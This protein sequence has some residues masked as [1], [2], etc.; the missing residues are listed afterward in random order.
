MVEPYLHAFAHLKPPRDRNQWN[1]VYRNAPLKALLLLAVGD[2]IAE[3]QIRENRIALL[4]VIAS[5]FGLYWAAVTGTQAHLA[6]LETAFA[7]LADDPFWH[8]RAEH[9][10]L[11]VVENVMARIFRPRGTRH[12]AAASLDE[13]LFRC[14]QQDAP[15]RR[16][17]QTLIETYVPQAR[18]GRLA[19]VRP[20]SV[21]QVGEM[22]GGDV[23]SRSEVDA[24][25]TA[26]ET[27]TA[28]LCGADGAV[29]SDGQASEDARGGRLAEPMKDEMPAEAE[30]GAVAVPLYVG[31]SAAS[32]SAIFI[33]PEAASQVVVAAP[34]AYPLELELHTPVGTR[35]VLVAQQSIEG[36]PLVADHL[37]KK[38]SGTGYDF[39]VEWPYVLDLSVR[40]GNTL[41]RHNIGKVGV[42]AGQAV[43]DLMRM[44]N[45]GIGSLGEVIEAL[46]N[47]LWT[48]LA[49][50]T[51]D[52]L[53]PLRPAEMN[54]ASPMARDG[55]TAPVIAA[56]AAPPE[57]THERHASALFADVVS[58][59]PHAQA[60]YPEVV[61]SASR[62]PDERTQTGFDRLRAALALMMD[63]AALLDAPRD[64]PE[65]AA[66]L[67]D[68]L[69][70]GV[71]I[72][73]L[74][75]HV[76]RLA[77]G[78]ADRARSDLDVLLAR[79]GV[80]DGEEK[81]LAEVG[82]RRNL[83]RERIRQ[84]E[85]AAQ[86][87]LEEP[88]VALDVVALGNL[89]HLAVM[90]LG[91][92]A[93][94]S[95][96]TEWIARL[97]PFGAV[98]PTCTTRLI[99][100]WSALRRMEGDRLALS[101]C[102]DTLIERAET[103]IRETL[104]AYPGG[105]AFDD[106]VWRAQK[107][108]GEALM[109]AQCAFVAAVVR[110]SDEVELVDGECRPAYR[111]SLQA[112]I[113]AAL[114]RLG[115]PAHFSEIAATYRRLNLDD[116]GRTDHTVHAFIGR[117]PD[118]FVLAGNGTFALADWGY[119]PA[120][121]DVAGAVREVL[122]QAE[123][124]LHRDE[125]VRLVGERYRWKANSIAAAL[126]TDKRIRAFGN[127][128][129]G[130]QRRDYGTFDPRAAYTKQFGVQK[131][132]KTPTVVDVYTNARGNTVTHLCLTPPMLPGRIP[133]SNKP[134]RECFA[135][136]G[137]L[138][139]L[140][141]APSS[142]ATAVTLH[143]GG[144]AVTGLGDWFAA[145]GVK[146]G[147][148]LLV[149]RLADAAPDEPRYL[150]VHAP[151][152]HE[153]EAM[154][155]V[156]LRADGW[157]GGA[158]ADGVQVLGT[159]NLDAVRQLVWHALEQPWTEISSAQ[160]VLGFAHVG[161]QGS[162]YRRLGVHCGALADGQVP[163][164]GDGLF[165]RPTRW[166]RAWAARGRDDGDT[167]NLQR[168]LALRLPPYRR[169]LRG[170]SQVEG[171]S[172]ALLSP[173]VLA[174]WERRLGLAPG[175]PQ[176]LAAV[177]ATAAFVHQREVRRSALALLLL[178]LAAQSHGLGVA[179]AALTPGGNTVEAIE[180][181]RAQGIALV[182]DGAGRA[183][184][185]ERVTLGVDDAQ[186]LEHR[187]RDMDT[188]LATAL[189]DAWHTVQPQFTA[190][191]ELCAAELFTALQAE[192]PALVREVVTTAPE[193]VSDVARYAEGTLVD[194]GF[195]Q[196]VGDFGWAREQV[197]TPFAFWRDADARAADPVRAPMGIC[198]C[199][200]LMQWPWD[201]PRHL[202]ANAHLA[203][204]AVLASDLGG[205]AER[206][207]H[208]DAGWELSGGPLV[209]G[210]DRAL[211]G[212]G[213]DLWDEHYRDDLAALDALAD[214]LMTLGER[215]GLLHSEGPSVVAIGSLASDLYY[216]AYYAEHDPI[217]RV[218]AALA[219]VAL[220]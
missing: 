217:G 193:A 111:G 203:L 169:H 113:I 109:P 176:A 127:A 218:R 11:G 177:E 166:G 133:L 211:R 155:L 63:T 28:V 52:E 164:R 156:G 61:A 208:G 97:V 100:S 1:T 67:L 144:S 204:L 119:D 206:I 182:T 40:V 137:D 92:V 125:V 118:V 138:D 110:C 8:V 64:G 157:A 79:A 20:A 178:L 136:T 129:F 48:H 174:M 29:R 115:R 140:C 25:G 165:F 43:G 55:E 145:L 51:L 96:A 13:A 108:G 27:G 117:F 210:L 214:A 196:L 199:E 128:F 103:A 120:I 121:R 10:D 123:Q 189:A 179:L 212:L 105:L 68:G 151:E 158:A 6:G 76:A 220:P 197:R 198:L 143:R 74:K 130:L 148:E 41:L 15:W 78:R 216:G 73:E 184:L 201:A 80:Y 23:S 126:A 163:G 88:A 160:A 104:D 142:E 194:V 17:Q 44:R 114:R 57:P 72:G 77:G 2:L 152:G 154:R 19:L 207:H 30:R 132:V 58:G 205:L 94:V 45:F 209:S 131:S 202:A 98:D 101:A 159:R 186:A 172:V 167:A 150:L 87:C 38:L 47:E 21:R 5:R 200:H 102:S 18:Q 14:L 62:A 66:R 180:H 34:S 32:L 107:A 213:Y 135:E 170:V 4:G 24:E 187:L 106:F 65:E 54:D 168:K 112:R 93:R 90:R 3:G 162:E 188:P 195:A 146:A 60:A 71:L 153:A 86:R 36:M 22:M 56:D 49:Q 192:A 91:G 42:L 7:D 173:L 26:G 33:E 124:P 215:L 161:T 99:A 149:E 134:A 9:R 35:C 84:L 81:T 190:A 171:Q 147:D 141:C 70:M 50:L 39:G 12:V 116:L 95:H 219:H 16:L 139:T 46:R 85:Q 175:T 37:R 69:S 75:E 185:D 53:V 183:A 83:S 59:P 31:E 181:L 191:G 122:L 89:A 82:K